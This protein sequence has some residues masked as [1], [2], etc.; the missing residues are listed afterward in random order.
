MIDEKIYTIPLRKE[1]ISIPIYR[2]KSNYWC[3][4]LYK[5]TP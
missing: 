5:K 1:F 2:K 3:K 4:K